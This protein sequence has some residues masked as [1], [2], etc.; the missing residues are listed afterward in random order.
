VGNQNRKPEK[1]IVGIDADN[2][3]HFDP[4]WGKPEEG[5]ISDISRRNPENLRISASRAAHGAIFPLSAP[6][7]VIPPYPHA[8]YDFR[9]DYSGEFVS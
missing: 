6:I 2:Q 4:V 5:V 3:G 1:K 7:L 9:R 8:E